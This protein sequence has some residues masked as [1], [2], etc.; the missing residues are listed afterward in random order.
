MASPAIM[1][2]GCQL[3]LPAAAPHIIEPDLTRARLSVRVATIETAVANDIAASKLAAH[4]LRVLLLEAVIAHG[5]PHVIVE[6]LD[7]A[8]GWRGGALAADES[9]GWRT[10]WRKGR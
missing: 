6:D 7:A 8:A 4:H 9:N 2:A 3:A 10:G 5:P 1:G